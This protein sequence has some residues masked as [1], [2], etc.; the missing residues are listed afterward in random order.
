MKSC[1]FFGSLSILLR[2]LR[3]KNLSSCTLVF[4]FHNPQT[5]GTRPFDEEVGFGLESRVDKIK[6][7]NISYLLSLILFYFIFYFGNS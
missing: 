4:V 1:S 5:L 6:L 2:T 7:N 3:K